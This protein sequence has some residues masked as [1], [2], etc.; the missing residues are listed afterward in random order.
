MRRGRDRGSTWS[1]FMILRAFRSVI[2]ILRPTRS[3]PL[4]LTRECPADEMS[5]GSGA[6]ER[7]AVRVEIPFGQGVQ[8]GEGGT[9]NNTFI[10]TYIAQVIQPS[11]SPVSGPVV[12]GDVPLPPAAF[13]PRADLLAA[14]R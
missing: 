2:T 14:L 5:G 1:R 13:Q 8:I 4:R 12:A 3:G 9:Q 6:G 10:Q 11:S 7:P